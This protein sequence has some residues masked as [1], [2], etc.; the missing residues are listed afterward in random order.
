MI[1]GLKK[2]LKQCLDGRPTHVFEEVITVERKR[3][4]EG[5]LKPE[6]DCKDKMSW[7]SS[8][9]LW[10]VNSREDKSDSDRNVTEEV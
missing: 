8:A 5:G 9:Q 4:D 2:E 3:E 10:S 7:M 1:E 6:A